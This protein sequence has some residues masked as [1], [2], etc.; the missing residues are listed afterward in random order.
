[1]NDHEEQLS[2]TQACCVVQQR[3]EQEAKLQDNGDVSRRRSIR[4]LIQVTAH[5]LRWSE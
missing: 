3:L 5:S 2:Q 1:M 4:L